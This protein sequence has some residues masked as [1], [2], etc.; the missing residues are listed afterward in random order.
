MVLLYYFSFWLVQIGPQIFSVYGKPRRT[1]NN[2]ES[3]HN[4]L[5]DKFQ[6]SHPNLWTVLGMHLFLH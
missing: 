4:K 6:V 5:K 2:I 3:F 1:N